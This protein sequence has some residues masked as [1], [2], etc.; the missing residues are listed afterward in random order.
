MKVVVRTDRFAETTVALKEIGSGETLSNVLVEVEAG[1]TL[2]GIVTNE[3]G[4]PV[5]DAVVYHHSYSRKIPKGIWPS[6]IVTNSTGRFEIPQLNKGTRYL[7]VRKEGAQPAKEKIILENEITEMRI[8]MTQGATISGYVTQYGVPI[9][10]ATIV[11]GGSERTL[12]NKD[13]YFELSLKKAGNNTIAGKF[14][15][16]GTQRIFKQE[17]FLPAGTTTRL[18]FHFQEEE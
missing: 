6:K 2:L 15:L 16:N 10:D 18:D 1:V 9:K 17:I 14:Y 11:R 4:N 5:A 8:E 3:L 7:E 12:T 13:G